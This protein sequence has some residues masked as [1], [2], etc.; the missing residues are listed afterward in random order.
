VDEQTVLSRDGTF[1]RQT[2]TVLREMILHGT[3][4]PGERL[5]EVALA[6]ALGISRGPLREA[7]QRLT[8]EGLLTVVSHRGSFVRTFERR[9]V[10]EL[11]DLRTALEMYVVRLVCTRATDEEL[12][13]LAAMV[14][15]AETAIGQE[16][17]AAYPADRDLHSRLVEIAGN[18]V[19]ARA[20]VEVQRQIMLARRM[21]ARAPV[22][23][24]Q[25]LGEHTDLVEAV[26]RRDEDEAARQMRRHLDEARRSALEAL[27]LPAT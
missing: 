14:R 26:I 7:I 2:E 23:A 6:Q 5:N 15:D 25:A 8:G 12:A 13:E 20:A 21:S 3:L 9:E 10:E 16:P 19:L 22:R 24:R 27:G 17:G 1:S 4:Q 11:Y 18:Q